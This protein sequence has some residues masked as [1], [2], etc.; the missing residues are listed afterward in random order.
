[1]I[2]CIQVKSNAERLIWATQIYSLNPVIR[3]TQVRFIQ[4][5]L[6]IRNLNYFSF[7]RYILH[8]KII[9]LCPHRTKIQFK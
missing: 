8:G 1:M 4:A 3:I 7:Y 9:C 6:Y 5:R 2:R